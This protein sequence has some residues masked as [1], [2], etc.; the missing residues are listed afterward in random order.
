MLGIDGRIY[1]RNKFGIHGQLKKEMI[2][3][4]F[5]KIMKGKKKYLLINIYLHL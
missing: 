3:I 1:R 4:I 2:L 5:I